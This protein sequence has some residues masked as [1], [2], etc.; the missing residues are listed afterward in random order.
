MLRTRG[1]KELNQ[2]A[3][4][5]E[6]NPM[7]VTVEIE[8]PIGS[9]SL[10]SRLRHK[11]AAKRQIRVAVTYRLDSHFA[12]EIH[13]GE[14]SP[15]GTV[16]EEEKLAIVI[17]RSVRAT[18]RAYR[19]A[20]APRQRASHKTDSDTSTDSNTSAVEAAISEA[21][22]PYDVK[23][24]EPRNDVFAGNGIQAGE[25]NQEGPS[26]SEWEES[27]PVGTGLETEETKPTPSSATQRR[28]IEIMARQLAIEGQGL[29]DLLGL[30]CNRQRIAD[31][32]YRE[33]SGLITFLSRLLRERLQKEKANEAKRGQTKETNTQG[34][35]NTHPDAA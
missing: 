9:N 16:I 10:G 21:V 6:V 28:T 27:K 35:Q 13:E 26:E 22:P 20:C 25:P 17:S 18:L 1:E 15:A 30:R 32:T 3:P 29:T 31:L 24:I 7:E 19:Q 14:Q 34:G 23:R 5:I 11:G 33:A 2:G 12:V 4:R 8:C